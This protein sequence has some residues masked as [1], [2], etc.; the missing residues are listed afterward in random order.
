MSE[1]SRE[2]DVLGLGT[3]VVDHHLLIDG[4]PKVD[5]KNIA[6]DHHY[7]VGGPVPTALVF[8]S[9]L[10]IETAFVGFWGTDSFGQRVADDLRAESVDIQA[11]FVLPE[12]STGFAHVWVDQNTGLR[13]LVCQRPEIDVEV[14]TSKDSQLWSRCQVLHLDGWPATHALNAA[15]RVKA[16]GGIVSL[17]TGNL[18]PGMKE[19]IP[20]VDLLN[21]PQRFICQYLNIGESNIT[22]AQEEAFVLSILGHGVQQLTITDGSNGATLYTAN[23]RIHQPASAIEAVDTNGAG[24]VFAG[25]LLYGF[26]RNWPSKTRLQFAA[27]AAALKCAKWGNRDALPTLEQVESEVSKLSANR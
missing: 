17:D 4:Y 16:A 6:L 1:S 18:K 22:E 20:Q 23:E 25:S 13:T 19:L 3:V 24:D 5:T 21:C 27:A 9:R 12:I 14:A 26:L 15:R 2:F 10:E 7:Q 11:S 8:L